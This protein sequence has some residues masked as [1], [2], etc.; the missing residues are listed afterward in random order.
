MNKSEMFDLTA[1]AKYMA[2]IE[3]EKQ[4]AE[5]IALSQEPLSKQDEEV[6]YQKC[7]DKLN[8]DYWTPRG[9]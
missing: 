6:I 2:G 1:K 8:G 7:L 3:V 4:N 5:R 9:V